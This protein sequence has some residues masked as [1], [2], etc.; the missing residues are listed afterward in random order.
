MHANNYPQPERL[1]PA[2]TVATDQ[3]AIDHIIEA[4]IL[5]DLGEYDK[6]ITY[7]NIIAQRYEGNNKEV[8]ARILGGLARNYLKL[9]L[10]RK[11]IQFWDEAI[12]F[13]KDSKDDAYLKAVFRN[14][15]SLAYINLGETEQAHENLL[16]S[17]KDFPL[18]QTYQKL[19]DLVLDKYKDF[20]LSKSYLTAGSTL[21][22]SGSSNSKIYI[23][24]V[25][26][27]KLNLAYITEGYAYHYYVKGELETALEKYLE[28]LAIAEDL[29]RVNLK[30][31]MLKK[32]GYLYREMGFPEKSTHYFESHISLSD[33]L[34]VIMNNSLSIP[35]H[36]HIDEPGDETTV[37]ASRSIGNSIFYILFISLVLFFAIYYFRK[38]KSNSENRNGNKSPD[39]IL[40]QKTEDEIL[41]K[42][43]E[44]ELSHDFLD[45]DMSLSVL[46]GQLNTNSKYFRQI[47][48]KY[49]NKDYNAYINE[50]RINYIVNKLHTDPEYLNY[51]ISYLA[52]ES[53]FSSHS[54]FSADFKRVVKSSPSDYI[55]KIRKT[56]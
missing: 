44:F 24:E 16:Q 11:A 31:E 12:S 38:T 27:Q 51:K 14:N 18:V 1:F 23:N 53:G 21:L 10:N 2:L 48:K 7:L 46:I 13:I 3:S 8:H 32:L 37:K 5:I 45:K 55:E 39:V 36:N 43:N 56:V 49:K 50:L 54:K 47:L 19:S 9:G 20:E 33:S 25:Y 22:E 26:T 41:K 34:R 28:V 35:V 42:L 17:L 15:K 52:E 6:S 30:M 4:Q 40:S 29:K